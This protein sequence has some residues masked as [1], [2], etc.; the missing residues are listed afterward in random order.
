MAADV[1]GIDEGQFFE[2]VSSL[3]CSG[4]Q[5]RPLGKF[6]T[7]KRLPASPAN[8]SKMRA[9]MWHHF[10]QILIKLFLLQLVEFAEEAAN[11]GKVVVISALNSDFRKQAW[12]SIASLMPL[13]E[14]IKNLSS[15]CKICGANA[16]FTFKYD[17]S[18][19]QRS[20]GQNIE[21]GG[22]DLY[23][24]LCRECFNEKSR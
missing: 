9:K 18:A 22:A 5:E 19:A 17:A 14:K 2:D 7:N 20:P 13:A 16:A 12:P 21:I 10:N 23:M 15:I 3:Q 6:C 24:P 8:N 11:Q 4:D 1:L